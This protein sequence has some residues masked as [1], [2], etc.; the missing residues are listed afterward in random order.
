MKNESSCLGRIAA[1]VMVGSAG[2]A[3]ATQATAE[4]RVM[5]SFTAI[6]VR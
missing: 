5:G 2:A 3:Y 6:I 1:A 4:R